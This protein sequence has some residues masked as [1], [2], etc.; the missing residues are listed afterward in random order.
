VFVALYVAAVESLLLGTRCAHP[1]RRHGFVSLLEL[2][3]EPVPELGPAEACRVVCT[4]LQRNDD[5]TPDAGIT[6]LYNWMTG[7][8]RVSVAPPPPSSGLQGKVTLDFFLAEA[9]GPS[10][11]CLMDC[12]RFELAG[13]PTIIAGTQMRGGLATQMIHVFND[14]PD[15]DPEEAALAAMIDAPDAYLEAV[16]AAAR[17]RRPPPLVPPSAG[18]SEIPPFSRFLFSLEQERR[19]PYGG[20]WLLKEM[21]HMKRTK[22][23]TLNEGGEEFEGP[24]TD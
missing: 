20:C 19:P 7:P 11:G 3:M 12:T 2:P 6:R 14:A 10:I 15:V 1:T 17:E 5:P 8:G 23:E 4:G 24:D 16:L 21:F 9:A 18:K 22:F 13:E